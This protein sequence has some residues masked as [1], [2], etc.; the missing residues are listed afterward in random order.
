M[1]TQPCEVA[2][3]TPEPSNTNIETPEPSNTNMKT[4][5]SSNTNI[6]ERRKLES[7]ETETKQNPGRSRKTNKGISK[8]HRL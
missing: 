4:P 5:E 2:M 7:I 8:F 1:E 6:K 3:E